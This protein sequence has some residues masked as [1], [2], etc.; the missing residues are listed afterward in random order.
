MIAMAL[1]P[2]SIRPTPH[3]LPVFPLRISV[4][5][6]NTARLSRFFA[7]E[8]AVFS[9]R[10]VRLHLRKRARVRREMNLHPSVN[11]GVSLQTDLCGYRF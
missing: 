3:G 4:A 10:F 1:L 6:R 11:G 2:A 9:A 5:V 7:V 8:T